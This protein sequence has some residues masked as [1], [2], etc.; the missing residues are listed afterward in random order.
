VFLVSSVIPGERGGAAREQR[1][2]AAAPLPSAPRQQRRA[3]C[4][5]AFMPHPSAA[6]R[7]RSAAQRGTIYRQRKE[8]R[9]ERCQLIAR[10]QRQRNLRAALARRGRLLARALRAAGVSARE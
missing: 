4:R 2:P 5:S 7:A 9:L 10:S 1:G 8:L 6:V 3:P